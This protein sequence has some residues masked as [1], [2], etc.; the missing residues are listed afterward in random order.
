MSA[1]PN[2]PADAGLRAVDAVLQRVANPDT[3]LRKS[4]EGA[5]LLRMTTSAERVRDLIAD[6]GV[7]QGEFAAEVGL[8]PSKMSK[9]LTGARRFSSLDLA[10]IAERSGVTV[11]WL[12]SGEE[13]PLATAARAASG[14]S[15][16][17]AVEE[18]GR[19]LELRGSAS[20]L[21]YPQPWRPVSVGSVGRRGA[22]DQGKA[23][24]ATALARL[25]SLGLD[26]ADLDLASVLEAG[27]G[28]DVCITS[29]GDGFDGLAA[30]T[31][32]AKLILVALTQVAFRQRFTIAHELGHL[33]AGD[34]QG[35]HLDPDV[36]S[37]PARRDQSEAAANAFAAALLMPETRLRE[38]VRPGFDQ[39]AFAGLALRL[40]VSPSALAIRL[41]TLRLID[42]MNRDAWKSLS[43]KQAT[44]LAGAPEELAAATRYA[45]APRRP[46]L[47]DRDLFTAYLDERTTLR[48]Y[49]NLLGVDVAKLRD[50]LERSGEIGG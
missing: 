29:L 30:S 33:L 42:A 19:L 21:G 17:R 13:P 48:P 34:D 36:Y 1:L 44:Q 40:K 23:L 41:E 22:A 46:G 9:S 3:S 7:S 26:P 4:Q 8:D 35:V 31:G 32:E 38:A 20:R 10:R 6:S 25:E 14:S 2:H 16:Q 11:D 45:T 24:A 27:F 39:A 5:R 15:A 43:A 18:A 50:D 28:V 12:L 49:A 47:L 37:R